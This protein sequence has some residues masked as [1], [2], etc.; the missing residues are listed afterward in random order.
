MGLIR[1]NVQKVRQRTSAVEGTGSSL[2]DEMVPVRHDVAANNVVIQ[3]HANRFDD[4]ENSLRRNNV[5]ILGLPE[6]IE[7]KNPTA[8]IEQWVLDKFDKTS[9]TSFFCG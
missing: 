2:E 4:M 8:Y 6:K 5:R 1:H 3:R 9:F 7:G